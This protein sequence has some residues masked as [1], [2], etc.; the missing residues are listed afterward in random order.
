MIWRVRPI[1]RLCNDV[2]DV[3]VRAGMESPQLGFAPMAEQRP[4]RTPRKNG[5]PNPN[6]GPGG[7]GMKVGRGLFGWVLFVGLAVVLFSILVKSGRS[8]TSI[9]ISELKRQFADSNVQTV[10]LDGDTI[11]GT[12][13]RPI[14][15]A[16]PQKVS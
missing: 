13:T 11:K 14:T 4:D 1:R 12:F 3:K 6:G 8:A 5:K 9:D 7:G 16:G 15:L 2:V 10:T